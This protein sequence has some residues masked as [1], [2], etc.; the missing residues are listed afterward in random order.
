MMLDGK[1]KQIQLKQTNT[2]KRNI[3][4]K[5]IKKE[6]IQWLKQLNSDEIEESLKHLVMEMKDDIMKIDPLLGM[7]ENGEKFVSMI[8]VNEFHNP[9]AMK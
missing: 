1:D 4:K 3:L 6:V 9:N 2:N 8:F 5:M 7:I